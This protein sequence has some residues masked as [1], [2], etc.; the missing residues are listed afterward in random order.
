MFDSSQVP[1][2]IGLRDYVRRLLFHHLQR[3][4]LPY[5]ILR[6]I[7]EKVKI[8]KRRLTLTRRGRRLY[9]VWRAHHR[10]RRAYV[11]E[12]CPSQ[13][14]LFLSREFNIRFPD[15]RSRWKMLAGGRLD[16]HLIPSSHWRIL[17]EP[18]VQLVAQ[19]LAA[20]LTA[21]QEG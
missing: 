8:L 12:A 7:H 14:V 4:Q 18:Y 19:R 6:D 13:M 17:Q 9:H 5:C 20:H 15:Y 1:P 16:C 10:S 2:P 3:G 21:L 11:P